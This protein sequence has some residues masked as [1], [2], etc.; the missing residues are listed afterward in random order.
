M[1][2]GKPPRSQVVLPLPDLR[3]CKV[4]RFN[5]GPVKIKEDDTRQYTPVPKRVPATD[6]QPTSLQTHVDQ[7]APNGLRICK[8][9]AGE[10]VVAGASR[11]QIV[12]LWRPIGLVTNAPLA[13]CDYRSLAKDDVTSHMGP[14]GGAILIHYSSGQKWSYIKRQTPDEAILLRC[15][16]S[17]QGSQGGAPFSGHTACEKVD[18]EGPIEGEDKPRE[19]IEIRF[20]VIH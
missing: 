16:D 11:V 6:P 2:F 10:D 8:A 9:C 3:M 19:S 4:Y 15:Y 13:Y 18:G 7:D 20:V 1:E 14:F 17:W 5:Q 12:N